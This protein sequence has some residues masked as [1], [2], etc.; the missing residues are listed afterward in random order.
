MLAGLEPS[1]TSSSGRDTRKRTTPGNQLTRFM[2]HKSLRPITDS[3]HLRIKGDDLT[4]GQPFAS[5]PSSNNV[6]RRISQSKRRVANV[7]QTPFSR[8]TFEAGTSTGPSGHLPHPY[9]PGDTKNP[10]TR[11]LSAQPPRANQ[12][13]RPL[14]SIGA[15]RLP[16]G[17]H[18]SHGASR[19]HRR[20]GRNR[21]EDQQPTRS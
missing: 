12:R 19:H 8:A 16:R 9:R 15:K 2:L 21:Q 4:Q 13:W 6:C 7:D 10:G 11:P 3:T 17:E 18:A 20:H 14:P 5:S 1:N